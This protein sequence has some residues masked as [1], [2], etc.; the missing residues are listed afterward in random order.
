[1]KTDRRNKTGQKKHRKG[2]LSLGLLL[3]GM[4]FWAGSAEAQGAGSA[5]GQTHGGG[6]AAFMGPQPADLEAMALRFARAWV[7]GDVRALESVFSPAGIRLHIHGDLYPSVT[8]P[9]A[10]GAIEA[11]LGRYP[12]GEAELIR[13]S[14]S[15]GTETHGFADLQWRT[16]VAGTGEVVIFTLFVGMTM[17]ADVWTV[18][19]IRVLA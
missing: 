1:V 9:R 3:V 10:L 15:S 11:F 17:E 14:Q 5:E 16:A 8:V 6:P 7:D 19:E 18:T 4:F 2:L 12:G 13:A